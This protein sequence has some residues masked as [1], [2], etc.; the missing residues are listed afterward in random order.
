MRILDQF[1][2]LTTELTARKKQYEYY[3]QKIFDFDISNIE[4]TT[5][6]QI[7]EIGTGNSNT[8]RNWKMVNTRFLSVRRKCVVKMHLSMM[9]RQL[10]L[11]ETVSV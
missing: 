6:S 5:L 8:K 11:W 7:A 1:T 10:L 3:Q 4:W 2:E 9:K